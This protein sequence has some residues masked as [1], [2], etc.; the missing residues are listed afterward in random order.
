MPAQSLLT[1]RVLTPDQRFA[2]RNLVVRCAD[3]RGQA[4]F[5]LGYC[6]GCCVSDVAHLQLANTYIGPKRGWLVVGHKVKVARRGRS[7]C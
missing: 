6:A 2:L 1:S 4:L 7:T 3:L 5:A